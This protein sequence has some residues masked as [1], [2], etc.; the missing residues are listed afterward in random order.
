MNYLPV[1]I[2]CDLGEGMGVEE[3]IMPLI[4]SANIACGGHAGDKASIEKCLQLAQQYQ[5]NIGL[6]PSYPD[7]E[8]F[9]RK[10][11]KIE[12]EALKAALR[13]QIDFFLEI[14]TA[15]NVTVHHLKLHGA[16]YNEAAKNPETANTIVELML[17]YEAPWKLFCP[18]NCVLEKKAAAKKIDTW[19]EAFLDRRYSADGSLVSRKHPEAIINDKATLLKQFRNLLFGKEVLSVANTWIPMAAQTFCI[20]GDHPK[21]QQFLQFL[22]DQYKDGKI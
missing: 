22:I 11:M 12:S 4:G 6:H 10:I 13:K 7:R 3:K 2:N 15:M 9:G 17:E 18:P 5:V 19:A 1:D 21:A 16:L 14:A 8:N 20:H